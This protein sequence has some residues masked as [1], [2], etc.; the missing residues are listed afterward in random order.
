MVCS[1]GPLTAA[2]KGFT[3]SRSSLLKKIG[4]LLTTTKMLI[5]DF[6]DLNL[7]ILSLL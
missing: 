2:D 5:G 1:V 7:N 3:K 6:R 4:Q